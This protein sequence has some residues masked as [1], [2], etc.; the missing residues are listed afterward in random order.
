M[1]AT[2]DQSAPLQA[3]TSIAGGVR[4]GD[5]AIVFEDGFAGGLSVSDASGN[6]LLTIAADDIDG[7]RSQGDIG[8]FIPDAGYRFGDILI[9]LSVNAWVA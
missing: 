5:I 1:T 9:G 4:V 6:N 8:L 7:N 2:Y 3:V